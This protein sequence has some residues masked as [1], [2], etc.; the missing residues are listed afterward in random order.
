MP[1][2]FWQ[3]IGRVTSSRV[4]YRSVFEQRWIGRGHDSGRRSDWS[5]VPRLSGAAATATTS[6]DRSPHLAARGLPASDPVPRMTGVVAPATPSPT[7]VEA[8][9]RRSIRFAASAALNGLLALALI[10]GP[11][12]AQRGRGGDSTAVA[13]L[14]LTPTKALKFTTDE[15]TWLSLD[16]SPDGRTIVFELLGDIYTIPID[17]GKAT[18]ITSGQ[19][20]DAQPHYSPDGK[21]DRLRQ[22]SLAV[23][24][25]L[26]RERRRHEPARAHARQRPEVPVADVHAGRQVH[27]RLEGQRPLHVLRARRHDGGLASHRRHDGAAAGRRQRAVDAAARR[28]TSSSAPR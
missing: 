16:L 13:G 26:D 24:Q 25:P 4:C 19:P 28:R 2:S 22:R 3:Q 14:P 1:T 20:F 23:G 12:A 21:Y 7:H 9:M 8:R 27:R 15:G 5:E 18:R 10:A 6:S 11:V 17:G